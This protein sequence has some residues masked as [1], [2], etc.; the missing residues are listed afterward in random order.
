MCQKVFSLGTVI[1]SQPSRHQHIASLY[2]ESWKQWCKDNYIQ[3]NIYFVKRI[4][5]ALEEDPDK[6]FWWDCRLRIYCKIRSLL[7]VVSE[8]GGFS[9]RSTASSTINESRR[10]AFE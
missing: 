2:P 9:G 8:N 6:D 1:G 10:M 7:A 4:W 5:V 3:L